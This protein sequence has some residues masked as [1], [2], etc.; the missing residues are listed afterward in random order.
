VLAHDEQSALT[1]LCGPKR[2]IPTFGGQPICGL[3]LTTAQTAD[4][5]GGTLYAIQYVAAPTGGADAPVYFFDEEKFLGQTGS[6]RGRSSGVSANGQGRFAVNALAF[7]TS[8]GSS[9][10]SAKATAKVSW[11]YTYNLTDMIATSTPTPP[12][13]FT[14]NCLG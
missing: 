13:G 5:F 9:C 3:S 8:P 7:E 10:T 12:A 2:P 11:V 14:L 1:R 6:L 4:G